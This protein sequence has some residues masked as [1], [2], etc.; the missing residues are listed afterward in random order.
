[1]ALRAPVDCKGQQEHSGELTQSEQGEGSA[2]G[3]M[4]NADCQLD[5]NEKHLDHL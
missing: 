2:A 3:M 1:M 4:V 5:W